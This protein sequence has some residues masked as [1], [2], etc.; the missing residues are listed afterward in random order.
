MGRVCEVETPL[1]L[2]LL[3]S[4]PRVEE[5]ATARV[6]ARRSRRVLWWKPPRPRNVVWRRRVFPV[7]ALRKAEW[8]VGLRTEA[9]TKRAAVRLMLPRRPSLLG[10]VYPPCGSEWSGSGVALAPIAIGAPRKVGKGTGQSNA[11]VLPGGLG[12]RG[13]PRVASLLEV[14]RRPPGKPADWFR[15]GR[16]GGGSSADRWELRRVQHGCRCG[17]AVR[18]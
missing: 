11:G 9:R 17:G 2:P 8:P 16:R 5:A 7:P 6:K 12:A 1:K 10:I 14:G 3:G 18:G 4:A 15:R 13:V